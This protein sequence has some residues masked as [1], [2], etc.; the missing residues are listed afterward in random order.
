L[1]AKET[2]LPLSRF[3]VAYQ[4]RLGRDPWMQPYTDHALERLGK[5]GIKELLVICPAFVSDCLETLEEIGIRGS[6]LFRRAGGT[7]LKLIPCLNT[8]PSW[9]R[10]IHLLIKPYRTVVKEQHPAFIAP[11]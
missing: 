5:A 7:E 10:A 6:E 1:F 3:S 9:I 4:S 2:G 11:D 8:D